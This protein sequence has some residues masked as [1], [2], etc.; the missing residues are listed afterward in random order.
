MTS[1]T[2]NPAL[3]A[4]GTKLQSSVVRGNFA[5]AQSDI[6]AIYTILASIQPF[7]QGVTITSGSSYQALPTDNAIFVNKTIG[8]ATLIELPARPATLQTIF[9][10]DAKG[11]A[12]THNITIDGNGNTIAGASTYTI[13]SQ[14]GGITIVWNGSEWSIQA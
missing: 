14:K 3:P 10:T 12:D 6:N 7:R 2:I 11:D 9:I 13:G 1:S 8:S 5:A 4:Q